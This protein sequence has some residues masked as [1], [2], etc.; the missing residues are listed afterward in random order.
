M[1]I[2]TWSAKNY[3]EIQSINTNCGIVLDSEI[4]MFLNAK[5]KISCSREVVF[6]QFILT[7]LL[8][9]KLVNIYSILLTNKSKKTFLEV[10]IIVQQNK[11]YLDILNYA[12]SRQKM[13]K[14]YFKIYKEFKITNWSVPS[15]VPPKPIYD[16][17]GF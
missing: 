11:Y 1:F 3:V 6:P 8:Q 17:D 14:Y 5:T 4:N 9:N 10:H 13:K 12:C 16:A 7:Y 2:L 15:V